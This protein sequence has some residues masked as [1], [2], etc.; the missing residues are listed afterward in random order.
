MWID[1]LSAEPGAEGA[2]GQAEGTSNHKLHLDAAPEDVVNQQ[3]VYFSAVHFG[4][5][6]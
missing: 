2:P 5:G 1:S 6:F 3:R 4:S